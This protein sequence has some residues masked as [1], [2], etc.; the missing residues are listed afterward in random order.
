MPADA[1]VPS[2]VKGWKQHTGLLFHDVLVTAVQKANPDT[3]KSTDSESGME[4]PNGSAFVTVA[5]TDAD[6]AK[7][8]F[9]AEYGTL[10][11]SKQTPASTK[12]DPPL[13]PLEG[14]TNESFHRNHSSQ[15][16]RKPSPLSYHGRTPW[17]TANPVPRCSE[18]RI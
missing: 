11:L 13:R 4:M 6:A 9:S 17:R 5:R 3:K 18:G 10:W 1:P 15:G 8:I 14:C 2:E 7:M 16:F 12:T